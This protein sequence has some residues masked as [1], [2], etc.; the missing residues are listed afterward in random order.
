MTHPDPTLDLTQAQWRAIDER[1]KTAWIGADIVVKGDVTCT[2][3][4]AID[5]HV[6]G[7]V[8]A[9]DHAVTI[10]AGAKIAGDLTGRTVRVSGDVVGD[11]LAGDLIEIRETGT[12]A[13]DLTAPRVS[14]ADGAVVN[15]KV[16]TARPRG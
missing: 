1:R 4:L 7:S 11:V 12:I 16:E 10:G 6:H 2:R 3:D 15:G 9:S 13:G 14:V 5:G 8:T